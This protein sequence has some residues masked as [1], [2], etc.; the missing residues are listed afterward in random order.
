M[1]PLLYFF[2][3]FILY[4]SA[5]L[6]APNFLIIVADDCTYNDLPVYG[7]ANAKT[8]NIDQLASEGLIFNQAYLA[9]AM[10]QPCRA[11]LYTGLYPMSNGCA[12]NH[13][14]SRPETKSLPHFLKPAGYRVGIAGKVHVK[15]AKA[16][17]FDN[18]AGFEPS[19]VHDPTRP[20]DLAGIR[21]YMSAEEPFCLVVCLVDPH[22]PWVMGDASKYPVEKIKLPPNLADTPVTREHFANYL[23]EI[24]YMDGQVGEIVKTLDDTGKRDETV[25]L[26]TSEQG[27]QF[28]GCKWTNWNTGLHTAL[29]ASW[30][31]RIPESSRT[32]ALVQYAD[33]VPTLLDLAGA[34]SENAFDGTSFAKV[35]TEAENT[36]REFAYG[37]HNNLPEGPAYPIRSVTDGKFR[38]IRNLSHEELYIEKHL[39]GGGK[40][41]NPYWAT[42]IGDDPIENPNS[43]ARIKRYM[44]RPEEQL[45]HTLED[46]YELENIAE[47][48]GYGEI[49]ARLSKALDQ[50]MAGES[51]PG[52]AVDT[53]EA[54]EASRKGKHL[55]GSLN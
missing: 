14:A 46:G 3:T 53:V 35:L 25:V 7:G 19:C 36:H 2:T 45:Y 43:Y 17:P 34:K 31:G 13:S 41:N 47:D 11:E 4:S 26:F 9:S 40:F 20:H 6:A 10:C 24:T 49:K 32:D 48:T 52:A 22:V 12:W 37:I 50:W 23:A 39:M 18:V 8:P 29:I 5:A 1:K 28:P 27:A 16:F 38:Y 21:D 54:L 30:P 51:D 42:W 33:V 15:P 55:H 44:L